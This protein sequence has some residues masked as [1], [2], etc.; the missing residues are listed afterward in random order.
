[1]QGTAPDSDTDWAALRREWSLPDDVAYLNHGSFGPSPRVVQ[2]ERER[3]SARLESQPM[4][5]FYRQLEPALAITQRRLGDLVGAA[6]DC[7]ALVD[8]ATAAMN[9]VAA[10]VRLAAGDEVLTTDHEYGAV[11]RLWRRKCELCGAKLVVQPLPCPMQSVE[12]VVDALFAGASP[13]TRLLVVSHVTSPTAV[14][15]PVASICQRARKA[16]ILTCVDGPHAVA[17]V[18]L[19]IAAVGCDY[20]TASCHKWLC[21][22]FGSGFL[23]AAA[24]RQAAIEPALVSWGRLPHQPVAWQSEF[25]WLGTRDPAPLLAIPRAIEFLEAFG[26]ARF[27]ER[28]HG[29]VRGVRA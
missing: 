14:V 6:A 15:L 13:R 2:L 23:Y 25:H 1:M 27:R 26:F 12:Q 7:L 11:L 29:L 22:P 28:T 8:N 17:M 19:D 21:A 24:E 20:Y 5:F 16:G 3:W 4:D 9:V 18:P 10:S